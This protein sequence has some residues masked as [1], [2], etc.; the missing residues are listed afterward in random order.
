MYG[1]KDPKLISELERVY[2]D[3]NYNEVLIMRK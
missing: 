1:Y 2:K 3:I